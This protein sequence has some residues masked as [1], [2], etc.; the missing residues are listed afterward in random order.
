MWILLLKFISPVFKM[1]REVAS[2]VIPIPIFIIVLICLWAYYDKSSAVK[3]AV[4]NAVQELVAGAELDA[5]DAI[6][7]QQRDTLTFMQEAA[8]RQ[9]DR[10]ISE[11]EANKQ[12]NEETEALAKQNQILEESLRNVKPEKTNDKTCPEGCESNRCT[13]NQQ[14]L[15][16]LRIDTKS[17]A[18]FRQ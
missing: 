10:L 1:I 5:K 14:F 3:I 8:K 18:P 15:D 12:F 13:I 16:K 7:T 17:K 6:I 9:N 4:K 2:V 11:V